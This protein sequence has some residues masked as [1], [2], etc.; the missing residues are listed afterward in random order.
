MRCIMNELELEQK[1]VDVHNAARTTCDR[2]NIGITCMHMTQEQ[3]D[4]LAAMMEYFK[5]DK[6]PTWLMGQVMHDIWGIKNVIL[7]GDDCFVPR[8]HGYAKK[9]AS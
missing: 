2:M 6:S 1:I 4:D 9:I 3:R 5:D 8:S 7:N